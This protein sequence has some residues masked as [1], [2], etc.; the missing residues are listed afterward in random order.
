MIQIAAAKSWRADMHGDT[1]TASL[2]DVSSA[3]EEIGAEN[4][5][6]IRD[7]VDDR[8]AL[9]VRRTRCA[10]VRFRTGHRHEWTDHERAR[11]G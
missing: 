7:G 8:N 5:L 2:H 1:R 4:D 9:R 11:R 10:G 3:L 6:V